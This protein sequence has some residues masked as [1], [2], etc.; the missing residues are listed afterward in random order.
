MNGV[1]MIY[2][3][4]G[5]P[6]EGMTLNRHLRNAP[7]WISIA[8]FLEKDPLVALGLQGGWATRSDLACDGRGAAPDPEL[9]TPPS[10]TG[11]NEFQPVARGPREF[12]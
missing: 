9:A 7:Q 8:K 5:K 4:M 2:S 11:V 1:A 10:N 6:G 3:R 12:Q